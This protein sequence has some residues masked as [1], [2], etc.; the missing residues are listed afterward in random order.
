MAKSRHDYESDVYY[1]VWR[2]GGNPDT[3]DFDRVEEA[4]RSGYKS[5]MAATREMRH[6]RYGEKDEEWDF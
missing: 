3:I 5:D 4:Y 2:S 1:E 6:Q